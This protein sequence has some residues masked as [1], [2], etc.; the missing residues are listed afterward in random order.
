MSRLRAQWT[1]APV[2]LSLLA[3]AV[4]VKAVISD[5]N[6]TSRLK[7][8]A[9]KQSIP[10][11]PNPPTQM[12]DFWTIINQARHGTEFKTPSAT[13]E[14]L[15]VVLKGLPTEKVLEFGR[16]YT[17]KLIALNQWDL[18][19][20][21]YVIAGGMSDDSFHYFRSWI[22]GKGETCYNTAL[23]DPGSLGPYVDDPD[24]DNELLEY[25]AVEVLESRGIKDDPRDDV[26]GSADDEPVGTPFDEDT[27]EQKFPKLGHN[28]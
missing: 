5:R 19:A 3:L 1:Y 6:Q 2:F 28:A 20:A 7:A 11:T 23:S 24:V 17:R 4:I 16:E 9:V 14:K 8:P 27:V 18:W 25:V 13:P 22:I 26:E 12:T 15:A 21:G 10:N